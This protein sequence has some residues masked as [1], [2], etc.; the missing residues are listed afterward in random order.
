MEAAANAEADERVFLMNLRLLD[1]ILRLICLL[2]DH[3]HKEKSIQF[4]P[5]GFPDAHEEV[6][7]KMPNLGNAISVIPEFV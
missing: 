7:G 4:D 6:K 3:K 5:K 1:C 2:D